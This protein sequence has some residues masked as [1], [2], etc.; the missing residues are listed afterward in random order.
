[1]LAGGDRYLAANLSGFRVLVSATEGVSAEH[2]AVMGRLQQDI[3][4][5]NPA[6]EDNYYIAAAILPWNG[7]LDSAQYVVRRAADA[8]KSDWLPLFYYGFHYYHFYRDPA[9]GAQWLLVAV[10]RVVDPTDQWALQNLAAIWIE[11]GYDTNNAAGMVEAMAATSPPGAF[12]RYLNIRAARLRELAALRDAANLHRDRY[13]KN[14]EKLTDLVTRG[15]ID[16]L[17][18]DPLGFGYSLDASGWPMLNTTPPQAP[19]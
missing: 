15:L 8:R 6:H 17:P 14:P 1:L 4:W 3:S 13:G 16:K 7:Q 2:F 9:A 5:L 19:K 12:R 10:P 18:L 11:K